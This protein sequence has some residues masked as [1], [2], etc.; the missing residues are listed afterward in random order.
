[1]SEYPLLLRNTIRLA[2]VFLVVAALI[3]ARPLLVP[4]FLSVMLAYLLYPYASW[5]EE[6]KIPRL[7]TNFMVI[8]SFMVFVGGFV[9]ALIALSASFTD[10]LS[11]IKENVEANM[12]AIKYSLAVFTGFSEASINS[13]LESA[14]KTGEYV[15]QAF[16]ATTNTILGVGLLPVYTFLL[17]LYR[18][19]FRD[20]ISMLIP[21][22]REAVTQN[23][24]NQAALVVPKY[25]KGLV[26]VCL[27]LVVLNTLGFMLIGV[28]YALL[29]GLIAALFNLIPY[30][31]T[32]LGYGVV[33]I[34]VLGTQSPS[35]A[36]AVLV[37]FFI[38]QFIENNILTPNITG[39]YVQINPLV[40]IFSLI[41]ASMI[42]GIPGMLIIIP[43]LGLFKIVCENVEDLKPLGFLLGTRGT[44]SHSFTIKSLQRRFGW[45]EDEG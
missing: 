7:L 2:F 14:S 35:L 13:W 5:L 36:A 22:E 9:Y 40:I 23:I 10:N 39:S 30:L 11:E 16:T 12:D 27:I 21:E 25:L 15:T 24:I 31:G 1:M 34:I 32:V 6:R 29:F 45:L 28:E 38:V 44:E 42:W 19:K 41:A 33:A 8:L 17:L 20:F 43:Y 3:I 37:Q 18:D 4:F 26:I